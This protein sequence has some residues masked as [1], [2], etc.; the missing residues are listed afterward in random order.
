M[1]HLSFYKGNYST[2]ESFPHIIMTIYYEDGLRF[3]EGK[4]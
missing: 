3:V 2:I 1:K 4:V